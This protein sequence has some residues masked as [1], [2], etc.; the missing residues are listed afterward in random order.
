LPSFIPASVGPINGW[1][2]GYPGIMIT[3]T[4]PFRYPHYHEATDTPDK[5]IMIGWLCQ[6]RGEGIEGWRR[7]IKALLH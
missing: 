4:A 1:Q 3:D 2:H 5:L 7:G 6:W